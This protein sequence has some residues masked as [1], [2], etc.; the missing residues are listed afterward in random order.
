[1]LDIID[2]HQH[3]WN[4]DRLKLPWVNGVPELNR[5]YKFNDYLKAAEISGVTRTVY[6]EVDAH[7]DHK[8]KEIDDMTLHCQEDSDLMLGMV[9]STDPGKPGFT[10]FL[11]ANS[12][13][14]FIKGVRQVLHNPE[15]ASR[16]CLTPEFVQGIRALGKRDLLFDICIRPAELHDAV[17]LCRQVPETTFVL[18]HCGNA[19]P[20]VVNG[21]RKIDSSSSD[22]TYV[23]S[24]ESWQKGIFKL[25]EL[26]NVYCKISG[27]VARAETDWNAQTLAPT[28]NTCL[29]AFG[30][31]RVVFGGDWPVCTLGAS[32]SQ[33]IAALKEIVSTRPTVVQEKMFNINAERLYQ[34]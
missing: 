31:D 6:M 10:E 20:Y 34:L 21:H 12:G 22:T 9:V 16:Y 15:Q 11:G 33:W 24:K 27:I 4:L 30:E 23:H 28:V 7:P 1:M 26:E 17:E 2:T 25:G 19:D 14:P 29:K 13:N 3:L 8:Q 5:S 32:L 18:D